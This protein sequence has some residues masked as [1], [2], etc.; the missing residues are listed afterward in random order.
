MLERKPPQGGGG[1]AGGGV[2][3]ETCIPKSLPY[4]LWYTKYTKYTSAVVR[5]SSAPCTL[6]AQGLRILYN[7]PPLTPHRYFPWILYPP[8]SGLAPRLDY[9]EL[10]SVLGL[11]L[12]LVVVLLLVL[13]RRIALSLL[14]KESAR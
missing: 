11:L 5:L 8:H 10:L 4:R 3:I 7:P 13:L 2:W 9:S 12:S 1:R 14:G 6:R